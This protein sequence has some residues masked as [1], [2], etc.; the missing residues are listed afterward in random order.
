MGLVCPECSRT[1][2]RW[3][4]LKLQRMFSVA[5][6]HCGT[7]VALDEPGRKA[8]LVTTFGSLGAAGIAAWATDSVLVLGIVLVLGMYIGFRVVARVGKLGLSPEASSIDESRQ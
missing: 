6:Q 7:L 5:C 3:E 1:F 2:S 8:L 4:L